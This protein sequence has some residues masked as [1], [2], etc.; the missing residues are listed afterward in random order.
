MLSLNLSKCLH[1]KVLPTL[2]SIPLMTN[3]PLYLIA[4]DSFCH[5]Q[6]AS[7]RSDNQF[8]IVVFAWMCVYVCVYDTVAESVRSGSIAVMSGVY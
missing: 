7:P 8:R 1:H 4:H 2:Q 6:H 3:G 5:D